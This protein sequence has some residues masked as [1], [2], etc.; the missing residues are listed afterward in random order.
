MASVDADVAV[1]GLGAFGASALWR[2]AGKGVDVIGFER[3]TPGH[4]YG[5][6]HGGSRMFRTACLEH[7]GLVDLARLSRDLWRELETES[8]QDLFTAS[9]GLL[10]G[11]RSGHLVPAA[12][13][14]AR[15]HGVAADLLDAAEVR[16]RFPAH[17]GLADD[18]VALWE[19]GAGLVRPEAAIRAAVEVAADAGAR[20]YADTRVSAVRPGADHVSIVTTVRE[21]RVRRVVVTAGAWLGAL[22]PGLSLEAVRMPMTWFAARPEAADDFHISRFPAFIRE[23]DDGTCLW[24]HGTVR[25]GEDVKLGLEDGGSTFDVVD[26]EVLDRG[27]RRADWAGVGERLPAAIPGLEAVPARGEIC[28]FTRTPDRQFVLG[29]PAGDPRVVVGGGCSGHGFKHA[30]GVGEVLAALV[31]GE[32]PPLGVEFTDPAR[33][34]R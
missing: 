20:V 16:R 19:P 26:A 7:P 30:T 18:H 5:S 13:A 28:L 23:L 24:G 32:E 8:G 10:A 21:F 25:A 34:A 11:P 12:L 17:D 6:S 1:I 2:L 22:V 31:V 4:A 3:H 29:R 14:V 33:F 9:G 27:F 15:A